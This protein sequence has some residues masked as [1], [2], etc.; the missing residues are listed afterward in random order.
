MRW[1][2]TS[3]LALII[4]V[5]LGAM[6][7]PAHAAFQ[8]LECDGAGNMVPGTSFFYAGGSD[9]QGQVEAPDGTYGEGACQ[10]QGIRHIF[11][12][13]ICDF[14]TI[15]NTV[16][17]TIYCGIQDA[18][19]ETLSIL[20]SVYLAVFGA[21][22]LIGTAEL[23]T[24]DVMMR[25][26]KV[27]LVWTFAT[28]SSWAIN[29]IFYFAIGVMSDFTMWIV[30]AIPQVVVYEGDNTTPIVCEM[31]PVVDG[32]M[33]PVFKFFDC[34]IYY[35]IAGAGQMANVK[36]IG[37]FT[38]MMVAFPPMS[39]LALWW[40]KKT[41][42]SIVRSLISFLMALAALAFL[43]S[44]TPIFFSLMLF[45]VTHHF[46][47]N[48]IRYIL[49][50]VIQ[51]IIVFAVIVL[52]IL[53]FIQFLGFFTQLSNLIFPYV[54]ID[55]AGPVVAP[56]EVWGICPPAYEDDPTTGAPMAS[57]DNPGF[58]PFSS[59]NPMNWED[60]A[61]QVLPP[62]KIINQDKFLYF[63][64]YHLVSLIII[65]FAFG[66]LLENATK[67]AQSIAGPAP[68]PHFAGGFGTSN[69][70]GVTGHHNMPRMAQP[71][72]TDSRAG[73]HSMVGRR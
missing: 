63:V 23:N 33:M 32:D 17:G 22:L 2:K 62:E 30:N 56:Q 69:W 70:G 38:V 26:F 35:I 15:L 40:V 19:T 43:I 71:G 45:Q 67:I 64:F 11:S 28:Q 73:F 51:V 72:G 1:L 31:E 8:L 66:V 34:M 14:V 41:F 52:W 59:T 49:A 61:R 55:Y 3:L 60:D 44:L 29:L 27:T 37:F 9:N 5:G 13:V 42:L 18:L 39:L 16:L 68:M 54:P 53:I 58:D 7:T 57:C 50:Y 65:T 48:W 46:F 36:I 21:Q 10:F 12:Q 6:P 20:L 4:C 25:L 24:K 47:E